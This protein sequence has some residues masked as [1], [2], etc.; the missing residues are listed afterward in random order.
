MA[1]LEV[2]APR[3]KLVPWGGPVNRQKLEETLSAT[4]WKDAPVVKET[5]YPGVMLGPYV[6]PA[7]QWKARV[8]KCCS[9][10]AVW[11]PLGGVWGSSGG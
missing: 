5:K 1:S 2:N 8:D 7:T 6:T 4:L 3:A 11:G 10:C 9:R